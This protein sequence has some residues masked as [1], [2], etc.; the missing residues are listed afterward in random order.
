MNVRHP[1]RELVTEVGAF[2]PRLADISREA[3]EEE[4]FA[5][6][7]KPVLGCILVAVLERGDVKKCCDAGGAFRIVEGFTARSVGL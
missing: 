5:G 6:L 7:L 4:E 1:G 3:A 2:P